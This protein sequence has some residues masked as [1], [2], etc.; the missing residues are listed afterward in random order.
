MTVNVHREWGFQDPLVLV[1]FPSQGL[2]GAIVASYLVPRLEMQLVATMDTDHMP[3]VASVR[4]G[5][6]HA[7]VQ[8]FASTT[9]CGI[10]GDCDQL[11]VIRSDAAPPPQHADELADLVIEYTREIGGDLLVTLEGAPSSGG[12][13]EVFA[14]PNLAGDVDLDAIDAE[15][16]PDGA[17]SGFSASLL[18]QGN[19]R[20][21]SVLCLF[22]AVNEELPD[23]EAA[24]RLV[25]VADGLVPGIRM[26]PEPL[27]ER[28]REFEDQLRAALEEQQRS[29]EDLPQDKSSMMYS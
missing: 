16:F 5:R 15:P 17:L 4:D 23:A 14:V 11:V 1:G 9:R 2:V 27:R 20:D 13:E 25:A 3:P 6:A 8:V 26:E 29:M 19:T 28:A 21:H 7:P 12:S 22:T 18:T 24:A 10:D